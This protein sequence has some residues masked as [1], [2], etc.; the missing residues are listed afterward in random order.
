MQVARGQ[1]AVDLTD[2]VALV[3]E[4]FSLRASIAQLSG[5]SEEQKLQWFAGL[6][7]VCE[8]VKGQVD[9]LEREVEGTLRD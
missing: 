4:M 5:A 6:H 8:Q 2:M 1:W 7:G 3:A 9:Q